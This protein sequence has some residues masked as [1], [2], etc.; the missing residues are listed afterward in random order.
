MRAAE[1]TGHRIRVVDGHEH[2]VHLVHHREQLLGAVGIAGP[3]QVEHLAPQ[4]ARGLGHAVE[5]R[6]GVDTELG[7]SR[8][9]RALRRTRA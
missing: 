3:E 1:A 5:V 4:L 9:A 6:R 2:R 7:R 8:E